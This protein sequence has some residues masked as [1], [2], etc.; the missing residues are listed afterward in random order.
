[1]ETVKTF[2][3][4]LQSFIKIMND[5]LLNNYGD[6]LKCEANFPCKTLNL[7]IIT[8]EKNNLKK[9]Y[10]SWCFVGITSTVLKPFFINFKQTNRLL[11]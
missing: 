4:V 11:A 3:D 5:C 9:T 6:S 10:F 7:Y 2:Q 8:Y 1:M